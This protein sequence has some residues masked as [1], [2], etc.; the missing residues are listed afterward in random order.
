MDTDDLRRTVTISRR[1]AIITK[2]L[3]RYSIDIAA[4]QETHLKNFGQ[5][6]ERNAGYTYF[7]SGNQDDEPN[8]Y[9]VAIAMK[10]NLITSGIVSQPSCIISRLMSIDISDEN[11]QTTFVNCYAPT[12][13]ADN[14][15]KQIFYEQLKNIVDCVPSKNGI[16]IAGDMNARIG[17]SDGNDWKNIIGKHGIG[18]RNENGQL[19]LEFCSEKNLCIANTRFQQKKTHIK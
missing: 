17:S 1:T 3:Q 5:L 19:L 16:I 6:T 12:L 18:Q 8:P 11:S 13:V 7:W 15:T 14:Q 10:T 9:G 4:L 2:E